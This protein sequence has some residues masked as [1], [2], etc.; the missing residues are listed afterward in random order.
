M[1]ETDQRPAP[2]ETPA[3]PPTEVKPSAPAPIRSE[4][5]A[6]P[7]ARGKYGLTYVRVAPG[8]MEMGCS[9]GDGHCSDDEE[10][11]HRVSISQGFRM[12]RTEITVQA[13]RRFTAAVD[14]PLPPEPS[15]NEGWRDTSQ[16][17]V[18]VSWQDAQDYCEWAGGRLPTEAEW[19]FAARSGSTTEGTSDLDSRAW[20]SANSAGSPH[21]VGQ[22][23]RNE[24]GLQDLQGGVWE[25][26]SDW[27]DA[28]Y[29]T[30]SPAEAPTGPARG[31]QR[32]LRG[33][34]WNMAASYLRFS[35]RTAADPERRST[36]TGFR[37]VLPVR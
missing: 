4:T 31:D 13:Y 2:P 24:W 18:N 22:K 14:R 9:P 36:V 28:D 7:T 19:E 8:A 5:P 15:S 3:L 35:E 29:Y 20:Y 10:P 21:G 23:A 16:A 26:C 25:W 17:V 32:V 6:Q 33:G 27:Y 12:T 30:S 34:A 1:P 37:C 11:R